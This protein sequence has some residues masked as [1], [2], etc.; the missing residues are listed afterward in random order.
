MHKMVSRR[1]TPRATTPFK[2][3]HLDLIQIAEGFNRD[4]W[5]FYFLDDATRI[6]FVY[7]LSR[8]SFLT[9]TIL[10][11]T[12]FIR[13]KFKYKVKTFHTDNEPALRE[14]FDT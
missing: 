6:N 5:V 8:K 1:A 2:R 7:T 10:I 11:F 12:A 9:N 3:V 13:R 4:K 14:K